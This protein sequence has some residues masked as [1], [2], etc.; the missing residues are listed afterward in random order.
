MGERDL[1]GSEDPHGVRVAAAR[2][3]LKADRKLGLVPDRRL[4]ELVRD[5]DAGRGS[6]DDGTAR[7]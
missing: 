6:R 5:A 4:V 3:R 1:P 7:G 2:A